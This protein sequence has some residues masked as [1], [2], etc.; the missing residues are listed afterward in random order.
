MPEEVIGTHPPDKSPAKQ[1]WAR[2]FAT[3]DRPLARNVRRLRKWLRS[4]S[5][6][7]PR[8]VVRPLVSGFL[9]G[10][11]CYYSVYRVFIC[12]PF[13]KAHCT[14]YGQRL[15]TGVYLHWIQGSGDIIVGDDFRID[16]KCVFSFAARFSDRP[17]LVIGNNTGIGHDC[18]FTI[19]KRITIGSNCRLSGSC[20][21]FDS[22]GHNTDPEARITNLPPDNEDVRPITIG[23]NVWIGVH[24]LIFP[25]VK[26]GEGSVI[27]A[28]SVVRSHVPPYSVVAGNPA[29]VVLR[30]PRPQPIAELSTNQSAGTDAVRACPAPC[31]E[32]FE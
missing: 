1:G 14:R 20:H 19:G 25:G 6:P 32:S 26:I 15:R 13:F 17:T 7:A 31:R 22:N 12:E 4:L 16:G 23:D 18:R 11:N 9:I 24:V 10:R 21:I 3:S 27:S 29:K 2:Y 30:L 8:V 28:G 5:V